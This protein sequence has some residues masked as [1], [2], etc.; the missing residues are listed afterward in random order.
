MARAADR[1][2]RSVRDAPAIRMIRTTSASNRRCSWCRRRRNPASVY[3]EGPTS[4]RRAVL[5]PMHRPRRCVSSRADRAPSQGAKPE[6]NYAPVPPELIAEI[7]AFKRT[8]Q[9]GS[10]GWSAAAGQ[11]AAA[12]RRSA[13][14][15]NRPNQHRQQR[16]AQPNKP[17]QAAAATGIVFNRAARTAAVIDDGPCLSTRTQPG[18]SSI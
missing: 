6:R 16:Q 7:E 2:N 12:G 17:H 3:R 15:P 11:D 13:A 9:A 5:G 10:G 8:Y 1:V 14:A 18:A 4:C